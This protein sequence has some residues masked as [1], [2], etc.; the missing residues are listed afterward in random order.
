MA[1]WI[2]IYMDNSGDLN[3]HVLSM[4]PPHNLQINFTIK[5]P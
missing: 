2:W 1:K 5:S 3:Y 4:K